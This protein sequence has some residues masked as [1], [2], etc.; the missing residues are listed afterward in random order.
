[1]NKFK[2]LAVSAATT[3]TFAI[4]AGAQACS[5]GISMY[6]LGAPYFAAQAETARITAEEAGCEVR[7]A[8]G[9]GS[10]Q[11]QISDVEDMV[12]A[13]I[14]ILI[15]NPRDPEGLV[16]SANMASAQGVHVVAIDNTLNPSADFITQVQSSN[17]AN[18]NLVGQWL[19][20]ELGDTT[21]HIALLSGVQG[22]LVGRE[23][24]LGVLR[25]L[26]NAQLTNNGAARLEVLGQGWGGWSTDGG[27]NAMEDLLT[28]H[29]DIN[30]VLGENDSMVLGARSALQAA[31]RLDEVILV[32]AADGQKEALELIQEGEYG[33]TG[34]NNPNQ[35]ARRA[36]EI[37]LQ[38]LNGELPADTPKLT[39][40][41]PAVITQDNVDSYYNPDSLF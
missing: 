1:M 36:V 15:L 13:G 20:E 28:A 40:T 39:V 6:T 31:D 38:A 26:I 5:V 7:V 16:S 37:G 9:G 35:I 27:L 18:G 33:A 41:E 8:D 21:P 29:P 19:A 12:V 34:L 17:T 2:M 14:D 23:R 11:K 24:R 30:V 3:M 25:G 22:S 32:A 4:S 10:M